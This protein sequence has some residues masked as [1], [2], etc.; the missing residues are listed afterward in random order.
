MNEPLF[1]LKY[2]MTPDK[3]ALITTLNYN[4]LNMEYQIQLIE[5]I[6]NRPELRVLFLNLSPLFV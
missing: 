1:H 3:V 5:N 6:S 2:S 4:M